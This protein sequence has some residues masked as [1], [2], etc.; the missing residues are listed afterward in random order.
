MGQFDQAI[1]C[2]QRVEKAKPLDEEA[3]KAIAQ[4]SVERTIHQG[5]YNQESLSG[6]QVDLSQ[7]E[8]SLRDRVGQ[9]QQ[10]RAPRRGGTIKLR[11][12]ASSRWPTQLR[13]SRPNWPTI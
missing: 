8:A 4:L 1:S 12:S 10:A 6:T 11:A 3:H 13:P 5:G 7:L 9:G 2:W